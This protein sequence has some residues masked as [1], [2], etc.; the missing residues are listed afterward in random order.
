MLEKVYSKSTFKN[1]IAIGWINGPCFPE[2]LS[3]VRLVK[4]ALPTLIAYQ[5]STSLYI[6]LLLI[7][8]KD[9]IFKR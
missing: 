4:E 9:K 5:Q 1:N 7:F 3:R 8:E 2:I 6:K